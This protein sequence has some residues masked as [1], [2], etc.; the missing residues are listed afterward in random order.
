[1]FHLQKKKSTTINLL[2]NLD[3][4]EHQSFPKLKCKEA[5]S[6]ALSVDQVKVYLVK[7]LLSSKRKRKIQYKF[8]KCLSSNINDLLDYNSLWHSMT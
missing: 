6:M 8:I 4:L 3:E 1:M 7:G 2:S 5:D